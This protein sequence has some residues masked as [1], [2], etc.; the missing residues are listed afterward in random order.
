[1]KAFAASA[2]IAASASAFDAMAVPDFVAGFIYGM[3][4]DNHLTEI[5]ACYQGGSQIV[6][7][8]QTAIGDFEAGDYF[9]GIMDAGK[10]WNEVGSA[11]TTCQGMDDD[12]TAI[13]A[14]AQIFTE[15]EKLSKTVAKR[16][17]FHGSKIK[18]DIAKEEA[19]WSAGDYFD[20]GIDTALALTEA[21]GPIQ[22]STGDANM[23]IQA[24]VLF[25]GGLL[26]GLVGDNHLTEISTC[27]V[28]GEQTVNDVA[29]IVKA[30]EA[31]A[32]FKAAEDVKATVTA[33]STALTA[34]ESMGDDLTAVKQW[35]AIFESP[36]DLVATVTKHLLLH[37]K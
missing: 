28:D 22:T 13:E 7:D 35:A 3:T 19:D 14:W 33:F 24:P 4:G 36:T 5:E 17:L 2:V 34:C 12:I 32:W 31:K 21:V 30:V 6:T 9:K 37:R 27:F 10:A 25:A 29:A 16:W 15:P 23:P 20:A 11:M 8:S 26:E 18:A 1:M